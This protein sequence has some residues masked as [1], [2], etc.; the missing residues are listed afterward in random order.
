MN[1]DNINNIVC[2]VCKGTGTKKDYKCKKCAGVGT[3]RLDEVGT[4]TLTED[5]PRIETSS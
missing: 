3:V 4:V 1:K 2:P 5:F